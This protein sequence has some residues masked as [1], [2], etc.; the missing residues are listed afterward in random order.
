MPILFK[1]RRLAE[2]ARTSRTSRSPPTCCCSAPR[3]CSSTSRRSSSC[4]SCPRSTS[5]SRPDQERYS[6]SRVMDE[7]EHIRE[8]DPGRALRHAA[9][10]PQRLVRGS[11]MRVLVTGLGTFWGSRLAQQLES[12]HDVEIDRRRSTPTEPRAAARA[13]RVRAGRLVN[14]SILD[15]IV[16]GHAGRHD[17]AH[18]PHRRLDRAQRP[19]AARDQRDRH[20]EPARGGGRRRQPGAQGRREEL[21][22]R[23]RRRTTRTRTSSARTMPRT[24]GRPAPGRAVAARVARRSSATSPIDNPHVTVTKLRFSNVLGDDIATPFS[25][26]LRLPVAPEVFGFDPRL[27]FTHEDDVDRRAHV[28]DD[29]TTCRASTTSPATALSP[30][31]EVCAIVGQ[32]RVAA[33]A[34]AHRPGRPSRCGSLRLARPAARGAQPAPLRTRRRQLPVQADRVSATSTRPRAR[35]TPS[36]AASGSSGRSARPT[37]E[38]RYERDV[39]T[40]FRHSPA[41]VRD[42]QV[43]T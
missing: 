8:H 43:A 22:P 5:T 4:A 11:A 27:Q 9:G 30:W 19:G 41:V 7:A 23:V 34:G 10:P 39:E 1:S 18:P 2:A 28:H 40:F 26:A 36:P 16:R 14:Y 35:S 17:P 38:Y 32:R 6:R 20:D 12:S 3:A 25:N 21:D 33:P 31:S 15:R 13:H 42:T 29:P 24:R 37:R